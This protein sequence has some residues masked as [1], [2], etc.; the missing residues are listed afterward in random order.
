M[1]TTHEITNNPTQKLATAVAHREEFSATHGN[2][3]FYVWMD[4]AIP[5]ITVVHSEQGTVFEELASDKP[6]VMSQLL[7]AYL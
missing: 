7:A 3:T 5:V 6:E 4:Q 2:H 1:S